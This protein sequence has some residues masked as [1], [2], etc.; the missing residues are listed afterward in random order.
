M[1]DINGLKNVNDTQGH[2]AG[3][4]FLKT[5]CGIICEIF[6]HSPVFRVGG[7]EFVVITQGRDYQHLEE[8]TDR[9]ALH[10]EESRREQGV[11]IACGAA[12]FQGD[13]SVGELFRRADARM[14]ENKK[15]LKSREA[16]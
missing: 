5:G 16:L 12:R 11:V 2:L 7:D 3:D 1:C 9:L 6:S 14:Y 13:A 8:L 4:R 10:N 15:L